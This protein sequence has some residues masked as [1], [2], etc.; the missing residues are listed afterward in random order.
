[1]NVDY[2]LILRFIIPTANRTELKLTGFLKN[3][4]SEDVCM[5]IRSVIGIITYHNYLML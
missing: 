3:F 1:M 4:I 5:I 2:Y